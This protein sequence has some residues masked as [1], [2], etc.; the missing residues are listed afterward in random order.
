[1]DQQVRKE[2]DWF[3]MPHGIFIRTII[4]QNG[5]KWILLSFLL[6]LTGLILGVCIDYRFAVIA[7]MIFFI[8][9]PVE[10]LFIYLY[11]GFLENCYFNVTLHKIL[12]LNTDIIISMKWNKIEETDNEKV[13]KEDMV[14]DVIFNRNL[15]N[16]FIVLKDSVVFRMKSNKGFLWLPVSAFEN[17]VRF[18]EF[19]NEVLT[20]TSKN[21]V[22]IKQ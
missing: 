8:L 15:F 2:S 16:D 14:R 18:T 19:V 10:L 4:I 21:A 7:L 6:I 13:E 3:K 9:L 11:Y 22:T 20:K 1:M 12:L 17:E 5:K